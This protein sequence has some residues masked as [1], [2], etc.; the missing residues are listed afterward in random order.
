VAVVA[1]PVVAP[2]VDIEVVVAH[3]SARTVETRHTD[4]A[5]APF[6]RDI[7]DRSLRFY[8]HNSMEISPVD[9]LV[10]HLATN[11]C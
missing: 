8:V 2:A 10:V 7:L 11:L 5:Q 6:H 1:Q 3:M 9:Q 4:T